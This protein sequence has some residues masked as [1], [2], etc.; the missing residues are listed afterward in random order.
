MIYFDYAA[1][2]KM[3]KLATDSYLK[4]NEQYYFHPDADKTAQ[5]V[6]SQVSDLIIKSFELKNRDLI[7]TPSASHAN[8]LAILALADTFSSKKHFITSYYEHNS[9]L[10]TF[11]ILETLGH[12]VTYI[13]PNTNGI[14]ES[15]S[16]ISALCKDTVMVCIMGVNNELGTTNNISAIFKT[17]KDVNHSIVCMSDLVQVVGKVPLPD[18]QNID[19]FTIAAHKIYG[20]KGIGALIF[21]D[22]IKLRNTTAYSIFDTTQKGTQSLSNKVAFGRAIVEIFKDYD[23]IIKDINEKITFLVDKLTTIEY[24]NIN[25]MPTSNIVSISL[26]LDILG[27]SIQKHFYDNGFKISTRSSCS[28]KS[29]EISRSLE[30]INLSPKLA[31]K[32]VRISISHHT[33]YEEINK[34]ITFIRRELK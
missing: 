7:F 4:T 1:T 12:R 16:V 25:V 32:T 29:K 15:D 2:T 27:E 26:N 22:K 11:S 13:K 14:I 21:S 31:D 19:I 24:V 34:L 9:V 10:N 18:F 5:K 8:S 3:S 17:V 23:T 6:E 20:P 28:S 30:A 33:T